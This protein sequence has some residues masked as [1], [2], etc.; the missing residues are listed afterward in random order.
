MF[1]P[2][3][4]LPFIFILG[5]KLKGFLRKLEQHCA[6]ISKQYSHLGVNL[7]VIGDQSRRPRVD[8]EIMPP[9]ARSTVAVGVPT[10]VY[11]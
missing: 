1:I 8:I 9:G 3:I 4:G 11:K 6:Q 2:L 7:R 5:S 10:A